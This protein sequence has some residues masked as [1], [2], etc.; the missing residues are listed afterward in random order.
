MKHLITAMIILFILGCNQNSSKNVLDSSVQEIDIDLTAVKDFYLL[1]NIISSI[2]Y[3]PL[4]VPQ[5]HFIGSIDKIIF[6]NSEYYLLDKMRQSIHV[7][8]QEGL[9]K[10]RVFNQ[11]PGPKEYS[12][13][14][15][16][17]IDDKSDQL[18][19]MDIGARKVVTLDLEGNFLETF[20]APIV[21]RDFVVTQNSGYLFYCPDES[22]HV[23]NVDYPP[24]VYYLD[25]NGSKFE[26]LV[27]IGGIDF[28]PLITPNSFFKNEHHI[29][30]F[31]P[32]SDT[33][34]QF[35]DNQIISRS[36][37]DYSLDSDFEM[38][39]NPNWTNQLQ[40]V[41]TPLLKIYPISLGDF[42][43]YLFSN[44]G[45]MNFMIFDGNE[46]VLSKEL[47]N[48]ID[49]GHPILVD[50]YYLNS[51]TLIGHLS[52]K[53]IE[54]IDDFSGKSQNYLHERNMTLKEERA[55]DRKRA[56]SYLNSTLNDNQYMSPV[57]VISKLNI[58]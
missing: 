33:T 17:D 35:H 55:L 44:N 13:I 54:A 14:D 19:I 10:R 7:Y 38:L 30:L 25:S 24:G 41:N 51:F 36:F 8:D 5:D 57:L 53:N 22:N 50:S 40:E 34:Y 46:P 58:E 39:K 43:S 56:I 29:E 45:E 4:K 15:F 9:F 11:G 47:I 2:E 1:S 6:H 48:D 42:K 26:H 49:A 21:C 32:Y 28:S 27:D 20:R 12:R 3:L 31:S 18:E 23:N 52:E 16:F 37:I